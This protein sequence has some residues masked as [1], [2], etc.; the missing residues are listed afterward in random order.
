MIN[1]PT[2]VM[3]LLDKL[4]PELQGKVFLYLSHPCADMIKDVALKLE[5]FGWND[6]FKRNFFNHYVFFCGNYDYYIDTTFLFPMSDWAE[7]CRALLYQY[8]FEPIHLF[9]DLV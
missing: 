9:R 7:R 2:T 3:E 5:S 1:I 6:G 4:P 8:D